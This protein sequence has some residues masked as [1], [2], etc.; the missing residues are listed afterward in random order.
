MPVKIPVKLDFAE[1]LR[2]APDAI[3]SRTVAYNLSGAVRLPFV[4]VPFQRQGGV[5]VKG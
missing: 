5:G 3:R 2:L 1:I 4:K